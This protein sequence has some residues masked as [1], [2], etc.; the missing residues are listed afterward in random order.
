MKISVSIMLAYGAGR[1]NYYYNSE[2]ADDVCYPCAGQLCS[3]VSY[4]LTFFRICLC[5]VSCFSILFLSNS[6]VIF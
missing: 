4:C 2:F 5:K 3:N 6:F 1:N